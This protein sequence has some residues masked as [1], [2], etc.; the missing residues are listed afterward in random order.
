[1]RLFF[2]FFIFFI[3]QSFAQH[4]GGIL[5]IKNEGQ[6]DVSI[7]FKAEI[8]G[9]HLLVKS[10]A[11]EYVFY[12]TKKMSELHG[13]S[14]R[15][16]NART[17]QNI[18]YKNIKVDFLNA[19]KS[20][21][22]EKNATETIYNF[23]QGN[24][25][26]KWKSNV[27]AFT[28]LTLEGVYDGVDMRLYSLNQSLKYEFIVQPNADFNQIKM[29]YDGLESLELNKNSLN[30]KTSVNVFKEFQPFSFQK[31]NSK[32]E[33]VESSFQ[34]ENQTVSFKIDNKY[35]H[36][37][38]LI[39]DPELVFST[40]S[41]SKSDNWAHTAAYDSKGNLYAGGSV[42]G[43]DFSSTKGVYQEKASGVSDLAELITDV[44]IMKYSSDGSKLLYA[45]Y[46]G[47]RSSEVPHSLVTNNRGELVI[48]GTTSSSNFPVS[49][50]GF[51]RKFGGG[52]KY[53]DGTNINF[54][55]GSDIFVT[56]LSENGDKLIGSTYIGGSGNDG[57]NQT[58]DPANL[59]NRLSIQNYGDEFRGEVITD[60]NNSI[61]VGSITQSTN[62]PTIGTA[63]KNLTGFSDG[64]VFNLN[65]DCS[66]L[67]WSTLFGGKGFDAIY[68]LKQGKS[69]A[70]YACG[71]TKSDDLATSTKVIKP[72]FG[73]I[74]DGFIVKF[75]AN[76]SIEDI[77]YLGTEAA[78]IAYLMDL[79]ADE[80]V[81]VFG[82]TRGLYPVSANVYNNATSGQFIHS[83]SKDL[84]KTNFSTV[85]G[86]GKSKIDIVPT[87]FMINDCGNIYLSGWGGKVNVQTG[88][89]TTSST[90]GLPVTSDAYQRTTTG[91]NFYLMILEKN[92]KQLLY[93]S[94]FGS[95]GFANPA[96]ERGDHVDGGTCRFDKKG[97]IYHVNCAC[98]PSGD[99]TAYFPLSK[100]ALEKTGGNGNCNMASFKFDTEKVLVSAKADKLEGCE[101][102]LVNFENTSLGGRKVFWKFGDG[103]VSSNAGKA[104]HNFEKSGTY[105]VV[106]QVFNDQSCIAKIDSVVFTIKVLPQP[107]NVAVSADTTIC[108]DA[109]VQLKASGGNSYLWSP[110]NQLSN[111]KIANPL[112]KPISETTTFKVIIDNGGICKA[113][114]SVKITVDDSKKDFLV[115]K[116]TTLCSN[117]SLVLS[118]TSSAPKTVWSGNDIANKNALTQTIKTSKSS[119][120]TI[121]AF[122]GDGC[123]P[124]KKINVTIDNNKPDFKVSED[125][126]ICNGQSTTINAEGNFENLIWTGSGINN[127]IAKSIKVSPT[128]TSTY[129]VQANYKDGCTP[130]KDI[131]V[132]IDETFKPDF[133]I[134]VQEYC[135]QKNTVT[136]N[137]KTST[138][139]VRFVWKFNGKDSLIIKTPINISF[140]KAGIYEVSLKAQNKLGCALETTKSVYLPT[141]I[142]QLN[143]VITPN[144]DGKNDTF[145][146]NLK[147]I[148]LDV[149]NR[150]GRPVYSEVNY[151]NDW[152][153]NVDSGTYFYLI[154]TKNGSECKGWIQVLR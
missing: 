53:F 144:N 154:K 26:S 120:Y 8:P 105:T 46:L 50:K 45:T 126:E 66:E 57:Y 24:D 141:P 134:D 131:Q 39:I 137:N 47:G 65:S 114:K 96:Q 41:G 3:N 98:Q 115:S 112:S 1:M 111:E 72:K 5:Y 4:Q 89:N 52:T 12:D 49:A 138:K 68:S 97:V 119:T 88:F 35:D 27:K 81:H 29:K 151:Q 86:S 85:F 48:F 25:E 78:D 21:I 23:F 55:N 17:S 10:N 36:S 2:F 28:E 94:F 43:S 150:E 90:S 123:K 30:F 64:V 31:I 16:R 110:A 127:S 129:S 149:Y 22:T 121:Q 40:Y 109:T 60:E 132:I 107:T 128:K 124:I 58:S 6:W 153:K 87:A 11:L 74:D 139:A 13:E 91:S 122:Y 34:L 82:L 92:A 9:G 143:N 33:M 83:L 106:M 113:E 76:N 77:T 7:K 79:D 44:V 130:K 70:I 140:E 38:P 61:F 42:F 148:S 18:E 145:N 101:P 93:G 62:F 37:K 67:K 146:T 69:G 152:G 51:Q 117:Q 125:K 54:A 104:I 71:A 103:F 95:F 80:N 75:Q 59:A 102:L 20:K 147:E 32:N 84:T 118:A 135:G 100:N 136:F 142:T 108:S 99:P 15:N 63:K 116:D 133:E 56:V 73:G 19:R 14:N